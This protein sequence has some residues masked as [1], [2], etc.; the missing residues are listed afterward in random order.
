MSED[1][2]VVEQRDIALEVVV[3]ESEGAYIKSCTPDHIE[4]SLCEV[5][6]LLVFGTD[7]PA[8]GKYKIAGKL[9]LVELSPLVECEYEEEGDCDEEQSEEEKF[10]E[11]EGVDG[12]DGGSTRA[13]ETE[14]PATKAKGESA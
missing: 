6:T 5:A 14:D 7:S 13:P 9:E 11:D 8:P 1:F 12:T 2:K 4:L 3:D 10:Q